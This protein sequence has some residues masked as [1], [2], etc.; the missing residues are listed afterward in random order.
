MVEEQGVEWL[1]SSNGLAEHG[2]VL[3]KSIEGAIRSTLQLWLT[4][5]RLCLL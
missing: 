1:W 2:K 4:V 5:I 3:V